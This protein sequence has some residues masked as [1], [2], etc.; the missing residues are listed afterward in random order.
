MYM[1]D[2]SCAPILQ[3]LSA[4][5]VLQQSDKF[6]TAFLVN[7]FTTLR[8]D[9][10]ANYA[11]ISALFLPSVRGPDVLCNALNNA[12]FAVLLVCG[13][14][15]QWICELFSMMQSTSGPLTDGETAS[16]S[17]HNWRRSP[18]YEFATNCYEIDE[19]LRF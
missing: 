3:F 17:I 18:S 1:M 10:V 9:S 4:V 7:F 14:T 19:N 12:L 11:L 8:K 5:S 15:Y 16:K 2:C 6:R 13:I